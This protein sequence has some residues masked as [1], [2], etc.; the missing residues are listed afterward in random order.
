MAVMMA[1]H[2]VAT[3][4]HSAAMMAFP[5]AVRMVASLDLLAATMAGLMAAD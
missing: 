3:D 4:T 2:S 1:F 5:K